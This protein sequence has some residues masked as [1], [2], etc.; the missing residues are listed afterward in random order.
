MK[1]RIGILFLIFMMLT[2]FSL[3]TETIDLGL[4]QTEEQDDGIMPISQMPVDSDGEGYEM[5]YDD[6]YK[7]ENQVTISE[8][9]DGNVYVMARDAK[10]EN[11][12]IYGN[13]FVM[14]EEIEIVDSEI[15]GSVFAFGE[16]LNFSGMTNDLYACGSKVDI[17][18]GS[19][20]WRNAKLA[21]ETI[22]IDGN[23]GRNLDVG[24]NQFVVGDNA[25]IEGILHYFSSKEGTIS[26]KA[27]IQDVQFIQDEEEENGT[28]NGVN[29]VFEIANVA[30]QTL[31]IALIIV[32]LVSKFKTLKRTN[33]IAMDFLKNTG[34]GA[35]MLIFLPI[36]SVVLMLSV[37]GVG[38]GL[39]VL[40]LYIIGLCVAIP[41]ASVEIAHRILA[42]KEE[43]K[44]GL[45]IGL[46]IVVSLLIWAMKFVPVIG[47]IIRFI[48]VLIGLGI[49]CSLIF[50]RNKK[51]EVNENEKASN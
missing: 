39:I 11:A 19:Y 28:S 4:P 44:K 33:N 40:V 13:L 31:I 42:K 24:V 5:I 30:F 7:M 18:A 26:E 20:V 15:A 47:G 51:E 35:L 41:I 8:V 27:Q 6:V 10:V 14:A 37:I 2:T 17:T 36:L 23:V 22:H 9:I 1:K 50:Q 32:F 38:F 25:K 16:K 43:V 49:I 34:K 12:V 46:S 45:W 21:G 3:A 29:Y 48:L